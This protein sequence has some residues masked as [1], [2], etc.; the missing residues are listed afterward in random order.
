[1]FR[2]IA[3][4]PLILG[5]FACG[6]KPQP[7]PDAGEPQD[8]GMIVVDAGR[9]QGTDPSTGWSTLIELPATAAATTR[10]G[11]HVTSIG[12]QYGQPI[13]AAIHE[14]PNGDGIYDDS[15]VIFA[16]WDGVA[17]KMTEPQ[18]IE[19]VGGGPASLQAPARNV[20]IARDASTGRIS[21]AY[22]K[23]LDNSVRLATSDDDGA[24][25]SLSTASLEP[26]GAKS[27]PVVATANGSTFVGWI[28]GNGIRFFSSTGGQFT[29]TEVTNVNVTGGNL[30]IALDDVGQPGL[31][32]FNSASGGT[33]PTSLVF[34]RP[35]RNWVEVTTT[36]IDLSP[37]ELRPSVS[38][39]FAGGVP[40]AAFHFRKEL[41]SAVSDQTTEL[42]FSKA[43][44]ALGSSWATP[45][46]I[47]RNGDAMTFHSTQWFQAITVDASGRTNIAAN[48]Q[49][50]PALTQCGGPKLARAVSG[51]A[52]ETCSPGG[53]TATSPVTLAGDW[54]SMWP[55]KAAKQT[56]VFVYDDSRSNPTV[57]PGIVMWR[58]P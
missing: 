36:A 18:T 48:F 50:R 46:A 39:T 56:M 11:A 29:Q 41:P 3:I 43:T 17:K 19:I 20:A 31:A 47:P 34:W 45:T 1:M 37:I 27:S 38:L 7:I 52:F 2:F 26:A 5:V 21:I 51:G 30:A 9:P 8:A 6:P 32:F 40:Q 42:W 44:D 13:I 22:V 12:D 10:I 28:Q 15:K 58:E 49:S 23:S 57:K 35:G 25:F 16:R 55:H 33:S 4:V 14:D 54:V 53:P 24:N